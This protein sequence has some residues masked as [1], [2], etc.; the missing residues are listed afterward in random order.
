MLERC[1][2]IVS[3]NDMA[4]SLV[5]EGDPLCELSG[6]GNSGTEEDL[7][8]TVRQEDNRLFPHHSSFLLTHIVDFIED[9]PAQLPRYLRSTGT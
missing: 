1:G 9:H 4:W 5:Q 6:V 3:I 7:T 8:H 2:T